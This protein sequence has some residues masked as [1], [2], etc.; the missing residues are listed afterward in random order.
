MLTIMNYKSNFGRGLT[1]IDRVSYA[2]DYGQ[3]FCLT[4]VQ[5]VVVL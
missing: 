1:I 2:V 3:T 5:N 4:F